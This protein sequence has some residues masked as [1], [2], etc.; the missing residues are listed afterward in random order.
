MLI[1]GVKGLKD[2]SSAYVISCLCPL[3]VRTFLALCLC[4]CLLFVIHIGNEPKNLHKQ[5]EK[6]F[7]VMIVNLTSTYTEW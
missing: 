6:N 3:Q 5:S 4:L 2:T 7:L 1:L